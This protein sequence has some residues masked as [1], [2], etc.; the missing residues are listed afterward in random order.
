MEFVESE[1]YYSIHPADGQKDSFKTAKDKLENFYSKR[2]TM[3]QFLEHEV[4]FEYEKVKDQLFD[5][6]R[7]PKKLS[8]KKDIIDHE[9]AEF[10]PVFL[11]ALLNQTVF[12]GE[13][14]D[15]RYKEDVH[16]VNNKEKKDQ[17][18]A[19]KPIESQGRKKE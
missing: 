17:A 2:M 18:S 9:L 16:K 4:V 15:Q 11:S 3:L 5:N 13:V 6:E 7:R 1:I 8:Q 19:D 10:H 12:L 14:E